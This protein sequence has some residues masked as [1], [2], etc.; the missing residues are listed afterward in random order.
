MTS[1]KDCSD[2]D[3]EPNNSFSVPLI[4]FKI[5]RQKSVLNSLI[6]LD[7]DKSAVGVGP[8]FLKECPAVL[9]P[10]LTKLFQLIVK[11]AA[12]PSSWKCGRVTAV[13]KRGKTSIA[14]NYRPVQCID[15]VGLVL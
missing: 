15:N 14:K 13:H 11:R 4:G 3:F 8:R 5:I 10:T 2:D 9:A 7:P 12:F 1:V 6:K